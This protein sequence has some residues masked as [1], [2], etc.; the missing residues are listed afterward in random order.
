M[1]TNDNKVE[2]LSS[3]KGLRVAAFVRSNK[4]DQEWF[5]RFNNDNGANSVVAQQQHG[6]GGQ[7]SIIELPTNIGTVKEYGKDLQNQLSNTIPMSF[8]KDI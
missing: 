7:R 5:L 6:E 2:I 3:A 1:S 8:F 4:D